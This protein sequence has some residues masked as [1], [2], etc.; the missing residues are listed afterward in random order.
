MYEPWMIWVG[1]G[2]ICLIIEIF[3]PGFFFMS[4]GIGAII[5][6]LISIADLPLGIQ[7]AIFIIVTF[8]I[9]LNLRKFSKK[10]SK[11]NFPTN[12]D[13]L[14]GKKGSVTETIPGD[15]KGF[16]KVGGEIWSAVSESENE[17]PVAAKVQVIK[18]DGNKLIVKSIEE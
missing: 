15:G 18:L 14:V 4:I 11:V 12:V 17:I 5:T 6:G 2:V 8:F 9:F 10:L 13:A 16:V 7:L 1:I 3:T